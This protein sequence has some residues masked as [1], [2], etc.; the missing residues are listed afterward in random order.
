MRLRNTNQSGKPEEAVLKTRGPKPRVRPSEVLGRAEHFRGILNDVWDRLWPRLSKAQTENDVT[1]AFQEGAR[2]YD[3]NFVPSLSQLLVEVLNEKTF[4]QRA[5]SMQRFIA[6]SI[7]GVGIVTPRRSRDICAQARMA[8]KRVH[9]ILRWEVFI[10][11]SCGYQGQSRDHGCPECGT[12]I[13]FP[14][15]LGSEFV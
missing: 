3:Q 8:K 9:H 1:K 5:K 6:D 12:K 15:N 14:V 13:E 4:P 2:P 11:C 10:E 7:A